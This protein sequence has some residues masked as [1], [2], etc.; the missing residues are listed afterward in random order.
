M[1]KI[2]TWRSDGKKI[3][4]YNVDINLP[5]FVTVNEVPHDVR[6]NLGSSLLYYTRYHIILR[7]NRWR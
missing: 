3:D 2:M 6:L 7:H 1:P 4:S 5:I